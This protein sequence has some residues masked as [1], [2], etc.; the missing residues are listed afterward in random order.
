MSYFAAQKKTIGLYQP[1][2]CNRGTTKAY[3]MRLAMLSLLAIIIKSGGAYKFQLHRNAIRSNRM[4]FSNGLNRYYGTRSTGQL[5]TQRR[6]ISSQLRAASTSPIK[7]DSLLPQKTNSNIPCGTCPPPDF[8][9]EASEKYFEFSRLEK[10]IYE[11][12]EES[13]YFKPSTDVKKKPYVI[14]M[15]PPNVTGYLHMGHA[16]FIG[17]QDILARFHRM[18]GKATLWLPGT[19]HAGV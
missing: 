6:T 10:S 14:P 4:A 2:M 16:M 17:L 5:F 1:T 12:W 18:R 3:S 7:T 19:D 15:P 13:G 11:W 9:S 8:K